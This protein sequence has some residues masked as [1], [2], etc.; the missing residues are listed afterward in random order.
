M[1]MLY[2]KR[3][4]ELRGRPE[5]RVQQSRLLRKSSFESLVQLLRALM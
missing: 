3:C 1:S 2:M 4:R 5:Q